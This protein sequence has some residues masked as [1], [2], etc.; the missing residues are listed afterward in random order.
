MPKAFLSIGSNIDPERHIP[1]ALVDL[2]KLFGPLELSSVY[3]NEAVGFEGPVFH[4][5]VAAF[6]SDLSSEM[7]AEHLRAIE[8]RHGRTR[9][10][11]KFSSRTLDIDLILWGDA[12]FTKG[13]L[14]I[15]RP[16]ITRYAFVLE[17]LAEL[18]PELRHPEIGKTYQELWSEFDRSGP[19]QRR[20]ARPD[21]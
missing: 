20:L 11:Q 16:E 7:I 4:N 1:A 13:R 2:R 18:A 3:E 10:S 15:P 5:L 9:E 17:P 12:I 14:Q 21:G 8:E 19:E 6:D